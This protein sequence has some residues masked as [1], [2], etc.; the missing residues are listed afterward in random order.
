MR[1]N[2]LTLIL[3]AA[4]MMAA[5][6]APVSA[7]D[8]VVI[9]IT[10]SQDWQ[11]P[12][13]VTNV[14]VTT[15]GAGG[16]GKGGEGGAVEVSDGRGGLGGSAGQSATDTHTVTPGQTISITIGAAGTGGA[17]GAGGGYPG[18]NGQAGGATSFGSLQTSNGGNGATGYAGT[19]NGAAGAN[20]FGS[21]TYAQAGSSTGGTGGTAGIGHGAGGG[22]GSGDGGDI[23]GPGGAGGHGAPGYVRIEYTAG[24]EPEPTPTP[25]AT[26]APTSHII[27]PIPT[28]VFQDL[29]QVITDSGG[30]ATILIP[31]LWTPY[32]DIMTEGVFWALVF[33]FI[34]MA[35]F[36]RQEDTTIIGLLG[37]LLANIFVR[38]VAPEFIPYA[39]AATVLILAGW[40]Y[41]IFI[42]KR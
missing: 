13:G 32:T 39:Y 30:N 19:I 34:V 15:V 25:T 5:F 22:G 38:F 40:G 14:T 37:I 23:G 17:A 21:G 41:F 42:K 6:S 24:D 7:S 28:P 16:G 18:G 8:P 9:E 26:P 11:V 36:Q 20:G 27:T 2:P 1:L 3:A 33:F 29:R 4:L 35:Y 10:S 31:L 12:A